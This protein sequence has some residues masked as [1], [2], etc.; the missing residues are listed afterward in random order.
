[1]VLMFTG[2]HFRHQWKWAAHVH[3]VT[4]VICALS[5]I[6]GFLA[7][8]TL[9]G[10][11]KTNFHSIESMIV[12]VLALLECVLGGAQKIMMKYERFSK[13]GCLVPFKLAHNILG[14]ALILFGFVAL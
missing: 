11:I 10:T 4:G 5:T 7:H 2:R 13:H 3:W 9:F 6:V 8:Y 12:S 1:M 14:Y